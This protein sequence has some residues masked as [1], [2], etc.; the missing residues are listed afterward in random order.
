MRAISLY[1]CLIF[2]ISVCAQQSVERHAIEEAL[3][4]YESLD[5]DPQL[6]LLER[7][8]Q[9]CEDAFGP[10]DTTTIKV[11]DSLVDWYDDNRNYKQALHFANKQYQSLIALDTDHPDLG[12]AATLIG[13]LHSSLY[14]FRS[15]ETHYEESMTK[16]GNNDALLNYDNYKG[17]SRVELSK[18]NYNLVISYA[19][20]AYDLSVTADQRCDALH[21]K[22]NGLARMGEIEACDKIAEQLLD[23]SIKNNL[24]HHL[25]RTYSHFGWMQYLKGNKNRRAKKL[26]LAKQQFMKSIEFYNKSIDVLRKST[27]KRSLNPIVWA[28]T[29]I[30][31]QYRKLND[32]DKAI[33]YAK[34]AIDENEKVRGAEYSP[35]YAFTYYNLAT[36]YTWQKDYESSLRQQ[37]NVIKCLLNDASFN[38]SRRSIPKEKLYTANI[39]WRLLDA[40]KEKSLNYAHLHIKHKNPEDVE[41]AE[42]QISNAIELIDIM[43]AEL[44]SD[45][46]KIYWRGRT[47]SIYDTAV[48]L[49]D[50]LGDDEKVLKYMEKSRSLLL[51]DEINHKD[52]L[53]MIPADLAARENTLREAVAHSEDADVTIF[54]EYNDYLDSLRIAFPSYYKYKFDVQTPTIAEVQ[55]NIIDD[56]TQV[57]NYYLTHDSLYVLNITSKQTELVTSP[58]PR[59]LNDEVKQLLGYLNNKDSLEYEKT[60]SDFLELSESLYSTL[61]EGIK[62]RRKNVIVVGDGVINYVPFDVLVSAQENGGPR[63]LIED[64]TFSN[65]PSLSVLR[66]MRDRRSFYNLLLVSPESYE[67]FDLAE[68]KQSEE[69]IESLQQI[70]N[71]Q[72][73]Q[74][75]T[76][77]FDNFSSYS[78]DYDVIH[79]STHSGIDETSGRPWIAFKDSLVSLNTIYQMDLEASLV[80]LSSCK[81]YDG[82][83]RTGE[84]VNSLARGF[85]FADAAAVIGSTW[86]LNEVAGNTI[87]ND[88][89]KSMKENKSKAESLRQAKLDYID[90]NPYK[91]PYYW[92]PLVL[93]GDPNELESQPITTSSN[94]LY[95]LLGLVLFVLIGRKLF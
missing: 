52:A 74:N 37:Q 78:S 5:N 42:R 59:N 68:L 67:N 46:T 31:N 50:W 61:F 20:Q 80:T 85:L 23:L 47:R 43:R 14:D 75:Q 89:Y 18:A 77:T 35:A 58:N 87:L 6:L 90:S 15:A 4:Q 70:S 48:E 49:S 94:F 16:I 65:A 86:N 25:G 66:K 63:Y 81:S 2:T 92:A 51:L 27:D 32:P 41:S 44:T 73:L 54:K 83:E 10:A 19:N 22:L 13:Y 12:K 9:K 1:L 82:E 57:L 91:S 21:L 8:L 29:N 17:L 36:K 95:L 62:E 56:S 69:E 11:Y 33:L 76:A 64:H 55:Q 39:K 60:Y 53:A 34:L 7:S 71:T 84:G 30:S 28:H 3:S 93:I 72:L 79:F 88:F 45:N 40:L 24:P 38:D 26:D